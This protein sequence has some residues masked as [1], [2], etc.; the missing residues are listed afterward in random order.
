MTN[1]LT[2]EGRSYPT[3]VLISSLELQ[4]R[5]VAVANEINVQQG[6]KPLV[7]LVVLHGALFFATD[8]MKSLSM[9]LQVET[10]RVKSY[11]KTKSKALSLLSPLPASLAGQDVLIVEDIVDTGKTI[12]FLLQELQ[13]V[14]PNS[15]RVC[16]LLNKPDGGHSCHLNYVG[17]TI[18]KHFVFG[19]GL[20]LFDYYRNLPYIGYLVRETQV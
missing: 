6:N 4:A 7:V 14:G 20:D 10:V 19:Y 2:V 13:K 5:I 9:P 8:L 18:A 15:L 12:E 3:Q 1:I 16:T 11:D 17:F